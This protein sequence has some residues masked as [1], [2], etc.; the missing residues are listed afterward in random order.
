MSPK[1]CVCIAEVQG[2]Q[3]SLVEVQEE[4][5]QLRAQ[6]EQ[7]ELDK[8]SQVTSLKEELLTQTQQLDSC[9]AR[10]STCTRSDIFEHTCAVFYNVIGVQVTSR[11]SH[12]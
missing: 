2:Q 11:H 8:D 12:S 9:Q 4:A 7:V 1:Y 5:E 3:A 6:L 10:V